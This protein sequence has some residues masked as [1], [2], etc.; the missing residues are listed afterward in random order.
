MV[1]RH[2]ERHV[3]ETRQTEVSVRVGL[4][5]HG[6]E[7]GS[8]HD[9]CVGD[10]STGGAVHYL[11]GDGGC[12]N[13]VV[14]QA[15][16]Q[17]DSSE[18]RSHAKQRRVHGYFGRMVIKC[19]GCIAADYQSLFRNEAG[20]AGDNEPFCMSRLLVEDEL[21]K[22]V[23]ALLPPPKPRR[24]RYPGRKPLDNR[25]ALTGILLVLKTGLAW[26]DL[27]REMGCGSGAACW[28]HKL[29]VWRK[30][31]RVLLAKLRYADK[32]DWSRAA[33]DATTVRALRGGDK[34]GSTPTDRWWG[35]TKNHLLTDGNR[36]PLA[37]HATTAS[38]HEVTNCKS[39]WSPCQP[40]RGSPAHP[41][42][43]PQPC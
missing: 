37:L 35:G 10:R 22:L 33:V 18:D 36:V 39:W 34:T 14:G 26:N 11:A 21:W 23:E 4:G 6:F 17:Q 43:N 31:H 27:P 7:F 13:L 42:T 20:A 28:V 1:D 30:L 40:S 38:Q 2:N 5:L 8:Q 19:S 24:F 16:T 29:G 32:I 12:V 9:L 41:S 15:T 25:A 3:P